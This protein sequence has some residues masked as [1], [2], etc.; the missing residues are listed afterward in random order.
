MVNY[1]NKL[2]I[3]FDLSEAQIKVLEQNEDTIVRAVPGSGK[4]T[5]L[6]LKIKN[7]L[8]DNPDINRVCCISYTNVNVEDLEKSCT[9][10]MSK[11]AVDKINFLTFHR[12]CLEYILTPFSYL[13]RSSAGLRAYKKIFNYKEHGEKLINYL[14]ERKI[15]QED[16]DT[17]TKGETVFYNFKFNNSEN[18]WKP[19]SSAIQYKTLVSYLNFLNK[20]KLIDFNL[21]GL[22]SLFILQENKLVRVALNKS[23]DWI[24]IDEFQDVSEIQCRII[25]N[26]RNSRV[27]DSDELK[28]FLVGDPN[29]SIYGFAGAN[30]R[31]MYDIREIFNKLNN[32]NCEIKLDRTHRC[33]ADVFNYARQNY[34]RVLGIIK[35]SDAV[36]SLQNLSIIDYIEDLFISEEIICSSNSG[37]V[38]FK[39][40][41]T[42]VSE[43]LNL[44]FSE[45]INDEVCCIGVNKYNSIDVYR[46]YKLQSSIDEGEDFAIYAEL[47]KDYEDKYGFKYF[48]LFIRYLIL[49]S[50]FYNNRIRFHSSINK[51]LYLLKQFIIDKIPEEEVD[52]EKIN[53]VLNLSS[54]LIKKL[55]IDSSVSSEFFSFSKNLVLALKGYFPDYANYFLIIDD[56]NKIDTFNSIN[57]PTIGGFLKFAMRVNKGK[58]TFE[59]KHIHK[60]K[61]L[62]YEQVIV[63]K[64]EDLPYRSGYNKTHQS[65]FH[66]KQG[67]IETNDIYDYIQE[68]NKLYVMLTR[69]KKN[70]YIIVNSSRMPELI[71]VVC[72]KSN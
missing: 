42:S 7:L 40:T 51:Y 2:N 18:V 25:E 41:V 27:S 26:I 61:G 4:T 44:K 58:I 34:N 56:K 35:G 5:I 17:I 1:R 68:L 8:L 60:I 54:N 62:E 39:N 67:V 50:D 10:R 66:N 57:E 32:C 13:Y 59:I 36:K 31:S 63:Q 30:P 49:K 64:L 24:F 6:T 65:I 20:N 16:I 71:E 23:I 12:F 3:D 47:Y 33:S 52:D 55:D 29:Q 14:S 69:S 22:L 11:D 53:Q 45:L 38:I 70:L 9:E 48:S 46:Q 15:L 21:I 37:T 43:I 19:I 28:W 72:E